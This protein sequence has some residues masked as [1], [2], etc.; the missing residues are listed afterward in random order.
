M[1]RGIRQREQRAVVHNILLTS[2]QIAEHQ[3]RCGSTV[4]RVAGTCA[5]APH[6]S[7]QLRTPFRHAF[8]MRLQ[9]QAHDAEP[10]A[11]DGKAA[12]NTW[13]VHQLHTSWAVASR[14]QLIYVNIARVR[15]LRAGEVV[16]AAQASKRLERWA[17]LQANDVWAPPDNLLLHGCEVVGTAPDPRVRRR[18]R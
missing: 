2:A 11:P 9:V 13:D 10:H 6:S 16:R 12:R 17:L 4:T 5:R 14:P 1:V 18:Q 8:V 15:R 3:K 7:H